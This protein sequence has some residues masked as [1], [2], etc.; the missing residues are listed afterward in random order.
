MRAAA[1]LVLAGLAGCQGDSDR[2]ETDA[3]ARVEAE[4]PA[5]APPPP[6]PAAGPDALGALPPA[7]REPRFLGRWAASEELC[8]DRAWRFT[9]GGLKTPA[10]SACRFDKVAKVPG[11]YDIEARCT[12]E[13]PER[14][15]RITLRFAESARAMLFEAEGIADAGLVYCGAE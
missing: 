3:A 5:D 12:A 10:G 6:A 14:A 11:G 4:T 8:A 9:A 13:G 7:D 15:E 1:M 2:A